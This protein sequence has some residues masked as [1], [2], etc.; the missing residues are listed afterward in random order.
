MRRPLAP[1]I[2]GALLAPW[3]AFYIA[4][5]VALHECAMHGVHMSHGAPATSAATEA[6]SMS[7]TSMATMDDMDAMATMGDHDTSGDAIAHAVHEAT[8]DAESPAPHDAGHVCT[9]LGGC[10]AAA[11]V[12]LAPAVLLAWVPA[13]I[14][15]DTH[16]A[17]APKPLRTQTAYL[18]PF[19]NGPPAARS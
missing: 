12:A 17:P 10:A 1:R 6:S 19:A 5:P 9:C 11:P 16:V 4:E 3:L 15:R 13:V 18:L 7:T 8:H 2:F 14:S